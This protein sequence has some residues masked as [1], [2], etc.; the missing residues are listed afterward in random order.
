ML[1]KK[2]LKKVKDKRYY[3]VVIALL[4]IGTIY[5]ANNYIFA[6]DYFIL[7]EI[8]D[9]SIIGETTFLP[10][11]APPQARVVNTIK[12]VVTAYSSTVAQ[13]DSTPFITASNKNVR[14]GIVANNLLQFG[15]NVRLPD[16]FGDRIFQVEDRMH[17]KKGNYHVD[18]WFPTTEEALEFGSKITTLEIL[19][20]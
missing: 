1:Y 18:V 17:R 14:N 7:G 15:T 19:G 3:A 16:L 2:I 12:V 6:E 8:K 4:V 20:N 9:L 13:T 5:V 10:N 11:I